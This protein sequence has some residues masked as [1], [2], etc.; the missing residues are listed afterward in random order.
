MANVKRTPTDY[1]VTRRQKRYIARQVAKAK[2]DDETK[3]VLEERNKL[4]PYERHI[5]SKGEKF[6]KHYYNTIRRLNFVSQE[7]VGSKFSENWKAYK[8]E[9]SF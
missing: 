6:F 5:V 1:A 9:A 8:E 2:Q 7:R 4:E 3:H